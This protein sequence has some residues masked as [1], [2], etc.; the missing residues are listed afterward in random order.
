M[1]TVTNILL[2]VNLLH[3]RA[4]ELGVFSQKYADVAG[5]SF[6]EMA[7]ERRATFEAWMRGP[8]FNLCKW[9]EPKL[10]PIVPDDDCS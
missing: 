2:K 3:V 6:V 8:A 7:R 9:L 10:V 4:A 5:P 1:P